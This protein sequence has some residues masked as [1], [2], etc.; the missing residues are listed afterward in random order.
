VGY[1]GSGLIGRAIALVPA[2]MIYPLIF[3][4]CYVAAYALRQALF[5]L[6]LMTV[7]GLVGWLMKRF[8]FSVPAFVIAF[9]L[10]SGAETSL[11]QAMMLDDSG[12][13]VFFQRP[14]ALIFFAFGLLAIFLR[15]RQLRRHRR[16]GLLQGSLSE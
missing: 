13:L 9:I 7:F 15:I 4:I 3:V 8:A 12:A 16:D 14:I 1:W 11:R 6:A 10:G 2:Q 5:D